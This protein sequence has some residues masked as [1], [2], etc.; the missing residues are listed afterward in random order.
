MASSKIK[1]PDSHHLKAAEGWVELGNPAEARAE[2]AR[3]SERLQNHREVL[4]LRWVIAA[5]EQDWPAALAVARTAILAH[6]NSSFG[7][8]HQAYALRRTPD[9]S[10]QAAWDALFPAM[11]KFPREAIIPYNLACY[12]CQMAQVD[13]AR[14]LFTRALATGNRDEIKQMALNDP[15]LQPLWKEI[16]AL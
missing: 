16:A 11:E 2:L 3:I 13:H 12:A 15:D 10:L 6:P 1:P 9:G 8:I 5:A 14:I 7:L 4:E